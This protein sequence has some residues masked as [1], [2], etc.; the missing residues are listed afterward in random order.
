MSVDQMLFATNDN[1]GCTKS[2]TDIYSAQDRKE[3]A[4]GPLQ[5]ATIEICVLSSC[6]FDQ[7]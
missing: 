4:N 2:S 1:A 7:R 5:Y 6:T 3:D